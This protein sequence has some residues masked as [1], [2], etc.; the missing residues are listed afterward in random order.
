MMMVVDKKLV[1]MDK[2]KTV[3]RNNLTD[4]IVFDDGLKL[5]G[6]SLPTTFSLHK[7]TPVGNYGAKAEEASLELG[8]KMYERYVNYCC[9]LAEDIRKI[10]LV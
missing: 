7:V 1:D 2:A 9:E 5:N 3:P 10:P 4:K 6:V 8:N